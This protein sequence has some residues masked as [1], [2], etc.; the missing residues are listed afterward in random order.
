M[1]AADAKSVFA[2][3]DNCTFSRHSRA[4]EMREHELVY[5]FMNFVVLPLSAFPYHLKYPFLRLLE[6]F[7]S[8]A[9]LVGLPIAVSIRATRAP[10]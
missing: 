2:A 1:M 5:L 10:G 7:G 4:K 6:G 8:H 3:L 9:I